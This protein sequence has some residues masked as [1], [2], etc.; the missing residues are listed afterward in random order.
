M[1]VNVLEA[2]H[3]LEKNALDAGVVEAFVI[4]S[5]HQLIQV[6]LHVLHGDVQ[7]LSVRVEEDVQGGDEVGMV[8]QRLQE[9]D[10]TKLQAWRK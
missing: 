6:T 10:L 7:L 2:L 5:L 3:D 9:D 8:G 1:C 4:P